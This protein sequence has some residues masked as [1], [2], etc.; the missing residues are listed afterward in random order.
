MKI[1]AI[2]E[3]P[4]ADQRYGRVFCLLD[5]G[6]FLSLTHEKEYNGTDKESER[7]YIETGNPE[8]GPAFKQEDRFDFQKADYFIKHFGG[9][10]IY[11]QIN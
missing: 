9:K 5:D 11:H 2:W 10:L 1:L 6:Q 4:Q 8:W 3:R 7:I